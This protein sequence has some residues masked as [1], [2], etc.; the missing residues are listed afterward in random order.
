MKTT[1]LALALFVLAADP[2]AAQRRSDVFAPLTWTAADT[3]PKDST[4]AADSAAAPAP[5]APAAPVV[6]DGPEKGTR[7]LTRTA[8]A[9]AGMAV[10]VGAGL[11]VGAAFIARNNDEEWGGVGEAILSTVIGGTVGVVV[12]AATPDLGAP[13][14]KSSRMLRA[15][16][17]ALVGATAGAMTAG[18]VG[19]LGGT[20]VGAAYA[21]D[22]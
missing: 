15:L 4:A 11:V 22:C 13:C 21:A 20:V 10:G 1:L 2:A 14:T 5:S 6:R 12:G 7:I 8:T 3:I 16:G 18:P 19:F 17:G 9:G